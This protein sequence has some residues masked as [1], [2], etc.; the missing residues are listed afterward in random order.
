MKW[1]ENKLGLNA[2][3]QFRNQTAL[4]E[5][6]LELAK[7]SDTLNHHAD[8]EISY[9]RLKVRIITHDTNSVT[10]KDWD[11]ARRIDE[12]LTNFESTAS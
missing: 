8:L 1:H 3:I 12:M 10:L 2:K 6:V 4:A 5:F 11:L 9:N 7:V